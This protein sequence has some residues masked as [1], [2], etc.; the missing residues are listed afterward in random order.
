[1][2]EAL[3]PTQSQLTPTPG[4]WDTDER[5]SGGL[6]AG[7]TTCTVWRRPKLGLSCRLRMPI[8]FRFIL[9][10]Y[11]I[12]FMEDCSYHLH[13]LTKDAKHRSNTMKLAVSKIKMQRKEKRKN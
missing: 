4:T 11:V 5:S 7:R 3:K 2:S 6:T 10:R 9:Q 13:L 1:L 8:S 12:S